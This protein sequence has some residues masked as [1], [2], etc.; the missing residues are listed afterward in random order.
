MYND[1]HYYPGYGLCSTNTS[2]GTRRVY[3]LARSGAG[4]DPGNPKTWTSGKLAE[5]KHE[6]IYTKPDGSEII[7]T[8]YP[9]ESLYN[10]T[11]YEEEDDGEGGSYWYYKSFVPV[12]KS[13]SAPPTWTN[14]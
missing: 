1:A 3:I 11:F 4:S 14:I 12:T 2:A 13:I 6:L 8:H 5:Y 10:F 7:E 9:N